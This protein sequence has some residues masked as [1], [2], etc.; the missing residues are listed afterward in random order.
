MPAPVQ[1]GERP[2]MATEPREIF[3]YGTDGVDEMIVDFRAHVMPHDA[4]ESKEATDEADVDPKASS[5]LALVDSS[6]SKTQ[7]EKESD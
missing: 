2:E 6:G 1:I 4:E 7:S 3:P 5:A